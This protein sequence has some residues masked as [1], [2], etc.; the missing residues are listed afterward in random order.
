MVDDRFVELVSVLNAQQRAR[1]TD[2]A[3]RV[4]EELVGFTREE[5]RAM[6]ADELGELIAVVE[7]AIVRSIVD[8]GMTFEE[9]EEEADA[10]GRDPLNVA[11]AEHIRALVE[12]ELAGS[13]M[14]GNTKGKK[15]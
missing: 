13:R 15:R 4:I 2:D 10:E 7:S 6:S 9:W 11:S 1:A 3:E 12:R 8:A 14:D 5:Q